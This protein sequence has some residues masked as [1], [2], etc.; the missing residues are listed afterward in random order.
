MSMCVSVCVFNKSGGALEN[1][2]KLRL[3]PTREDDTE[4]ICRRESRG[5]GLT[6]V[7]EINA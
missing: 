5:A 4:H 6:Y 3:S 7:P 2:S 1:V